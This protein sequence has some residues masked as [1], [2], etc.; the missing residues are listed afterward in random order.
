M[1]LSDKYNSDSMTVSVVMISY[2]DEN[3]IEDCLRSIRIQDYPQSNIDIIIVDGGSVDNTVKLA[4]AY[5]VNVIE[6]PELK[7]FPNIRGGIALTSANSDLVLFF[8]ADNRLKEIDALST[9]VRTFIDSDVIACET[10]RFGFN[11]GD[12]GLSKYFALIGGADPIAVGLGKADRGPYDRF[13][14]HG[15]GD[16]ED[17]KFF[18]KVLFS[19]DPALIPTLGANGFLIRRDILQK[20]KLSENC[21]HIDMCVDLIQQGYNQF[22]FVKDKHVIHYLNL[23]ILVFMKRRLLYAN[24]YDS[25]KMERLYS[26]FTSKDVF[27]LILLTI[28]N[29]TFVFPVLR[30][31]KGYFYVR[32][33]AWFY[34]PIVSFIF[35]VGYSLNVIKM[36]ISKTI[37]AVRLL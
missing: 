14:W 6:K 7:D 23:N 2:N 22:A 32:E 4:K 31:F 15:K 26:V 3:I 33:S 12:P 11:V 9:M 29:L 16:I 36:L 8:S 13:K 24:M 35:T 1:K 18:Y 27:K 17:K 5:K 30:S 10:L 34:H 19:P 37:Q 21:L 28:A 25:G 20:T